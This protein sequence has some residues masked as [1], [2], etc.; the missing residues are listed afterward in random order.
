MTARILYFIFY[1]EFSAWSHCMQNV[2]K[3]SEMIKWSHA[4]F[5][6]RNEPTFTKFLKEK[7]KTPHLTPSL[8]NRIY[9][10]Q[11]FPN[12]WVRVLRTLCDV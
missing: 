7:W 12:K 6:P 2:L 3:W 5:G 9:T 8:K 1:I 4:P 11:F 10:I